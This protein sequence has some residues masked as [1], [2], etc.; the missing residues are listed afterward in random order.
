MR[1][2][3][4][5]CALAL[6]LSSALPATADIT[7]RVAAVAPME[8]A[9]GVQPKAA[10]TQTLGSRATVTPDA[11]LFGGFEIKAAADV[12]ILVRGNSLGTLGVTQNY[13]DAPRVRV[14]TS[15]GQDI[16]FDAT[17]RDGFGGCTGGNVYTDPVINLYTNVRHQAPS[18]RDAC[19]AYH[20]VAGVYTFSVTPSI[21]GVT[22]TSDTSS[23]SSG[24][25]L[26]EVT[27]S[28]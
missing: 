24:E 7:G 9:P 4:V 23:P 2:N 3:H 16:F 19:V 28:P 25:V 11:T 18:N 10:S 5:S 13:L 20:F 12:Y 15:T 17:G 22:T 1:M 14:Y 21:P 8:A 6:A 26:F 27:L